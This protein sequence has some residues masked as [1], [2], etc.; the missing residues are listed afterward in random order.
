M[1]V[2]FL[3][4]EIVDARLRNDV[5]TAFSRV[6][7]SGRF[8]LGDE[9]F[10]FERQW[11]EY[12]RAKYCVGVGN[13]LDALQ[14][15]LLA[16]GIA[17]GD[18]VIV[19]ANTYVATW[20]AISNVGAIPVAVPLEEGTYNI[21]PNGIGHAISDRT[22]AVIPVHL[23]GHP[24]RMTEI[25]SEARRFGLTVIEDAAQA[26]GAKYK[27]QRIGSHGDFVAWSFYPGKNL[28]A[29][30]DG[31]AVTTN[32]EQN[33]ERLR[34][35]RNYGSVRRYEHHVVGVNS[36]LDE[37]QAAVLSAKLPFLDSWIQHRKHVA[38]R[39]IRGLQGLQDHGYCEITLPKVSEDVASAWHL[40]V[41][42]TSKRDELAKELQMRGVETLIHYPLDVPRQKAYVDRAWRD[43][44]GAGE[45]NSGDELLSLPMGP[46]L[47][48]EQV[49]HTISSTID[50]WKTLS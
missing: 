49:E 21:D 22:K 30:G 14:L 32:N 23:Y 43:A 33:F 40:F 38:E 41:I 45:K 8:V 6:V 37:I 26:H 3:S 47:T 5:D 1:K 31:G 46:H 15:S 13:G 27:N 18:E 9:L 20:F 36:R 2:P 35:L 48:D 10:A 17:P 12:C 7:D 11:A 24:C 16:A 25:L 29:L 50:A 44:G 19:P 34:A 39:Y 28:G 4:L 42:K